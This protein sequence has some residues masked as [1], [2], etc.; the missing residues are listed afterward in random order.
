MTI[1]DFPLLFLQKFVLGCPNLEE[2]SRRSTHSKWCSLHCK[3]LQIY[4][5]DTCFMSIPVY[6]SLRFIIYSSLQIVRPG[7]M[8]RPT[9]AYKETHNLTVSVEDTLFGGQVSNLQVQ[10]I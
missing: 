2:E 3:N 4:S 1:T 8:E 10:F 5:S 7:G 6:I 9:D